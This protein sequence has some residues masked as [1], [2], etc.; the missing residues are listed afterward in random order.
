MDLFEAIIIIII[1]FISGFLNTVAGGGSLIV[2]PVL[3]FMGLPPAVANG[4]NRI[5]VLA[6]NIT[7]VFGFRSKG[8]SAFPYSLWLGISALVGAVI[9]AKIAIDISGELFNRI[10]AVVLVLA[11]LYPMTNHRSSSGKAAPERMSLKHQVIGMITF[12]FIGIY[13]GFIQ[14]GV[15]F[16]IISALAWINRFSLVK[17]NSAKVFVV[18]IY[19]ISAL[20]IFMLE[21]KVDWLFGIVLAIGNVAGSWIASRLSVRKGDNWI[22]WF[23]I[24]TVLG[25]AIKLWFFDR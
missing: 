21:G 18:M 14:A 20:L 22:R 9:G 15:G 12:F 10:L 24:I 6:Q 3:I 8:V 7:A 13:G 2:L 19:T 1:G 17:T 4:T 23:I 5:A 25:L 16:L 11:V